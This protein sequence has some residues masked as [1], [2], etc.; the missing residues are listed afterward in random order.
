[1]TFPLGCTCGLCSVQ[2][3]DQAC[4]RS[5]W[6][7]QEKNVALCAGESQWPVCVCSKLLSKNHPDSS[8]KEMCWAWRERRGVRHSQAFVMYC[9]EWHRGATLFAE[10][11]RFPFLAL[12]VSVTSDSPSMLIYC[13]T[14]LSCGS[15]CSK[16]LFLWE[17]S[18]NGAFLGSFNLFWFEDWN[19]SF[20]P[21]LPSPLVWHALSL[22][23]VWPG[24]LRKTCVHR[25]CTLHFSLTRT[26]FWAL[27]PNQLHL[28][29]I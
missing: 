12:C 23:L 8:V 6:L 11:C 28:T 22:V 16:L 24:F 3:S 2:A 20:L 9:W 15:L 21:F 17:C 5:L 13:N 10:V 29:G 27:G 18:W 14:Q 25:V 4:Y 19:T 26:N 7:I 1:M